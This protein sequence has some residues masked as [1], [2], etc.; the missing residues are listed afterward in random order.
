MA[1]RSAVSGPLALFLEPNDQ[2]LWVSVGQSSPLSNDN[3]TLAANYKRPS[4]FCTKHEL[5]Y[6][7]QA[8]SDGGNRFGNRTILGTK[9]SS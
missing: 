9:M 2:S 6:N 5:W 4:I 3:P 7:S 8:M 1:A